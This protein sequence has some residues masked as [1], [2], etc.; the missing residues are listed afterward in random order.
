MDSVNRRYIEKFV[1]ERNRAL[2]NMDENELIAFCNK[3]DIEIPS[4][5]EIFWAGMHKAR[6]QVLSIPDDEKKKSAAWLIA[7]GFSTEMA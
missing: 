4:D 5:K 3:Y 6:L 1:R 7:H 2:M